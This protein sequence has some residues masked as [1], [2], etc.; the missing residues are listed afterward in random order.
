MFT[1]AWLS[2]VEYFTLF[3]HLYEMEINLNSILKDF[4]NS[5][6][7]GVTSSSLVLQV[8]WIP[9]FHRSIQI[10]SPSPFPSAI[11]KNAL[12]KLYQLSIFRFSQRCWINLFI[13]NKSLVCMTFSRSKQLFIWKLKPL[14]NAFIICK[15]CF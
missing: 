2:I 15:Y 14:N 8:A 4:V 3:V 7:P 13:H 6:I 5:V 9:Q 10:V 12:L 11:I 1:L